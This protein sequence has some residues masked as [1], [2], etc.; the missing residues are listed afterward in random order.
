MRQHNVGDWAYP[1]F[2]NSRALG[3]QL[4]VNAGLRADAINP[5]PGAERIVWLLASSKVRHGLLSALRINE[6]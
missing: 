1:R 2:G 4:M 5:R 3:C 6:I